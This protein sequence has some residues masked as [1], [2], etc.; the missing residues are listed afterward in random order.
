MSVLALGPKGLGAGPVATPAGWLA[1]D[2]L[3]L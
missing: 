1:P 2:L 3:R